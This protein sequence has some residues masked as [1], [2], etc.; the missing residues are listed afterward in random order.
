VLRDWEGLYC[1]QKNHP[2]EEKGREGKEERVE[3]EE[4]RKKAAGKLL[5]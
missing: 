4:R 3:R 2:R 5:I 1:A